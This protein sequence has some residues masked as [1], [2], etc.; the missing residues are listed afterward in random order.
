MTVHAI[1][2]A[3]TDLAL[4]VLMEHGPP[5]EGGLPHRIE[6]A[7]LIGADRLARDGDPGGVGSPMEG[8]VLSVQPSHI[9]TDWRAA[10][11]HWGARSRW[12]YAFHSLEEA[13]AVLAAGS[14]APVEPPDPRHGLYAAVT[15]RDLEGEPAGGWHPEE[16][17]STERAFAGY[18]TGAARAA[19][20]PRQGRLT[21]GSF[22]DLV[23]WDRDPMTTEPEELLQLDTRLTMVAGE[24]VWS[25]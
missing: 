13:G 19:G 24:T 4:D 2:D 21:P 8:L 6:H 25:G 11:R 14:D 16:R 10:D 5:A 9:M 1:G 20:D 18:T 3:A 7:Q 15:R 17:L 22:A 12:A 23:A